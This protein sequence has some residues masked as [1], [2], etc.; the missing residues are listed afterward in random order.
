M[1]FVDGTIELP[2]FDWAKE[3]AFVGGGVFLMLLTK[4]FFRY[5]HLLAMVS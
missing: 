1:N 4:T 5:Y 3:I 2:R